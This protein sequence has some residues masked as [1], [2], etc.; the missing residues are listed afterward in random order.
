MKKILIPLFLLAARAAFRLRKASR[1]WAFASLQTRLKS[2]VPHSVVLLGCPEIHGNGQIAL[3]EDLFLYR[4]LHLET[5]GAGRIA[6]GDR[7]VISRGAHVVSFASVDI[8]SGSM[9]GEYASIRDANHD[10]GGDLP[11]RDAPH[12]AKPVRIGRNVWIA[13]GVTVLPGI[14]IGDHAVVGANAVVTKDVA[15]GDVVAGVPARSLNLRRA[16]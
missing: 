13:R 16:A 3:G 8:G 15:P 4:D 1:L 10:Y 11:L 7:V 12:V 14:T 6:I 2:R 9:I 5:Q